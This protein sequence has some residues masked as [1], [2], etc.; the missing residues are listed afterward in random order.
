MNS[1]MDSTK[2]YARISINMKDIGSKKLPV[3]LKNFEDKSHE[4]FDTAQYHI[5][6]TGSSVTFVEGS[7]F[8]INGLKDVDRITC[9]RRTPI[10]DRI[11]EAGID[12][13][14]GVT[15]LRITGDRWEDI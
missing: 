12:D 3:L 5:T 1:F 2:R 9:R 6:F 7:A 10:I 8:I 13:D 15:L 14:I 4:I 11:F